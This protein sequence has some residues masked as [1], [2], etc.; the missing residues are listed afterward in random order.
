MCFYAS[1][2]AVSGDASSR[3]PTTCGACA[4]AEKRALLGDT[5]FPGCSAEPE[6]LARIAT[7]QSDLTALLPAQPNERI[8]YH[9][10]KGRLAPAEA[11]Q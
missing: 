4:S 1:P 9:C 8:V 11:A 7:L 5:P 2:R 3:P 6:A 10:Q